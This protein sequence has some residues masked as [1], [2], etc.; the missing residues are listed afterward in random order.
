[1][2]RSSC[3]QHTDEGEGGRGKREVPSYKVS[4]MPSQENNNKM[5]EAAEEV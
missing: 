4:S 3:H 5:R 2:N 1:M